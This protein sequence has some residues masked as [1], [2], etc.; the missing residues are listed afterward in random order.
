MFKV[1]HTSSE[2][3]ISK[4]CVHWG[5]SNDHH[6]ILCPKKFPRRSNLDHV[7]LA[8]EETDRNLNNN[9]QMEEKVLIS[10]GEYAYANCSCGDNKSLWRLFSWGTTTSWVWLTKDLYTEH[11]AN[12]L[13]LEREEDRK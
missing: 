11:L 8:K 9:N 7:Q 1:G 10:S 12:K 6:R 4:L 3:K 5:I 2:C 13:N